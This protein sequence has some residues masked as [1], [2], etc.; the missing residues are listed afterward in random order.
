MNDLQ[1]MLARTRKR[2]GYWKEMIVLIRHSIRTLDRQRRRY[3][4]E[5]AEAKRNFAKYQSKEKK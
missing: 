4:K 3:E 5:L 2:P 1:K